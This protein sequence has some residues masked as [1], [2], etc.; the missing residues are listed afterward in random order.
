M[1]YK[2]NIFIKWF[3]IFMSTIFKQ[4]IKGIF[5]CD[6]AL[7]DVSPNSRDIPNEVSDLFLMQRR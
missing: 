1:F 7:F 2:V 3:S 4:V 6:V 5:E